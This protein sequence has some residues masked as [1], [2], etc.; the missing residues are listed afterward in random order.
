LRN[1]VF[2][3]H[4]EL[5]GVNDSFEVGALTLRAAFMKTKFSAAGEAFAPLFDPFI[6]AAGSIPG[7]EAAAGEAA[8]LLR[9]Y[10]PSGDQSFDSYGAGLSYDPGQWF[11]MGEA[12]SLKSSG[13]VLDTVSGYVSGGYRFDKLTP[14][15][16]YA[17]THTELRAEPG[18]PLAGLP[19]QLAGLGAAINGVVAGLAGSDTSQQ[20]FSLGM[21]WDVASAIALKAQYDYINLDSGSPGMLT[22]LQPAFTPGGDLNV[23]S[24]T[25]DFVF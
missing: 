25:L 1:K 13:L 4:V 11:V 23:F 16:T 10:D 14:Y 24:L 6:A 15:L 3:A 18:V 21:R 12:I 2:K 9:I 5:W 7:G 17:R 20:T 22:N 8:R 19:P